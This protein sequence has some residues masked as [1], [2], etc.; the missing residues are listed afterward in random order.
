MSIRVRFVVPKRDFAYGVS[1]FGTDSGKML[2][3]IDN[4][5]S[6]RL[7]RCCVVRLV[8]CFFP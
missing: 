2:L 6:T 8:L 4:R 1:L 7:N 5:A 3:V